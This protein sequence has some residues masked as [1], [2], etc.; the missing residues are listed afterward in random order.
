M[1]EWVEEWVE[2]CVGG[3]SSGWVEKW[4]GGWV[5]GWVVGGVGAAMGWGSVFCRELTRALVT[6]YRRDADQQRN[7][8]SD[9]P[10]PFRKTKQ[11]RIP[12][13]TVFIGPLHEPAAHR[14]TCRRLCSYIIKH[15]KTAI[16]KRKQSLGSAPQV[17]NLPNVLFTAIH[18]H[19]LPPRLHL[20]P[21]N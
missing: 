20:T 17:Y 12:A 11:P 16:T 10:G 6:Y 9:R 7:G 2:E 5:R 1:E 21:S 15:R 18:S 13:H 14:A 4:V 19:N 3:W 8:T